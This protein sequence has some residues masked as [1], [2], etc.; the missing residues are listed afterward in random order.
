MEVPT[1][2]FVDFFK[3]P[4]PSGF[5]VLDVRFG[6]GRDA[7]GI[8]RLGHSVTG[9]DLFRSGVEQLGVSAA[10]ENLPIRGVVA[11]L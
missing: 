3:P 11:D 6:Q 1:K 10:R 9:A 5:S 7:L 4:D 2:A 8:A